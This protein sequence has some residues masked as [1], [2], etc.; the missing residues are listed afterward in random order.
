MAL[1]RDLSRAQ[2]AFQ[3]EGGDVDQF[4]VTR[5]RGTEGFCRLYRFEIELASSEEA[6]AFEDIVG[7]AAVLSINTEWGERWFHG[8]VSRFEMVGETAEQT[9]YRAELVP[10][11]WLLT[12][13][14]NS[15]I[16]QNK[17]SKDI[18]TQVLTDAGIV[19]DRFSVDGLKEILC[20]FELCYGG[21]KLAGFI[22]CFAFLK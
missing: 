14:Y 16:F 15:R 2:L 20:F 10:A 11:V 3:V 22:I 17:S 6:V 13:R 19:E 8:I 7:K 12:H 21:G 5:Y 1:V 18:I 9:Y 4:L